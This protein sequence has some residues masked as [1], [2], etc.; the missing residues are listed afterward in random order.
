MKVVHILKEGERV[1]TLA[2][3]VISGE[4]AQKLVQISERV[5]RGKNEKGFN[6]SA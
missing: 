1:E 3:C 6:E 4:T 5:E 2:G